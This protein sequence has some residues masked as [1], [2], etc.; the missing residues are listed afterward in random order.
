[1]YK[2]DLLLFV[3]QKDYGPMPKSGKQKMCIRDR[4]TPFNKAPNFVRSRVV[5]KTT[6]QPEN[7]PQADQPG[8]KTHGDV[9]D[10]DIKD[11]KTCLLYTSK[12]S[13]SALYIPWSKDCFAPPSQCAGRSSTPG[14]C[15][16]QSISLSSMYLSLI[17]I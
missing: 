9:T 6:A 15:V 7:T 17:H 8:N 16:I 4:N 14:C 10:M 13:R 3:K 2:A 5:A 11:I 1:M 12:S